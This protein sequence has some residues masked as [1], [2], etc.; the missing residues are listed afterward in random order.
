M[1][2]I[3]NA[4]PSCVRRPKNWRFTEVG[5]K[6]CRERAS[7]P[8]INYVGVHS[9]AAPCH[10]IPYKTWIQ[11]LQSRS[12]CLHLTQTK[13]QHPSHISCTLARFR[14]LSSRHFTHSRAMR[15]AFNVLT[16]ELRWSKPLTKPLGFQLATPCLRCRYN[17]GALVA[18]QS[19]AMPSGM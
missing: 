15:H 6:F 11:P 9:G 1:G 10:F 12:S 8:C 5:A 3:S 18:C 7:N 2:S 17:P 14:K 16:F 4:G 19:P 13:T